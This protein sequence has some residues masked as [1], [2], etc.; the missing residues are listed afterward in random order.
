MDEKLRMDMMASRVRISLA[1]L[2]VAAAFMGALPANVALAEDDGMTFEQRMIDKLMKGL[3][4]TDGT[5]DGID[6]RERPSLVVPRNLDLPP[7]EQAT[8]AP[9]NWPKDPDVAERK[10]RRAANASL[11]SEP[12]W[13]AARP[14]SPEE[15]AKGRNPNSARVTSSSAFRR[16]GEALSGD[17]L[18]Y[19]GNIFGTIFKGKKQEAATFKGEKPRASLTAPPS[20]YQTPSPN[21]TYGEGEKEAVQIQ[22]REGAPLRPGQF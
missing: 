1:S 19:K 6:Y 22:P 17:E 18:G 4:A 8:A 7:P 13:K 21:Y 15:L 2:A 16:D 12:E 3:G 9:A 14:L 5:D 10:A 20:G 11:A